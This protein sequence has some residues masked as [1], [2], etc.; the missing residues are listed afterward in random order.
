MRLSDEQYEHIKQTVS[1]TFEEYDIK[2]I[3]INVFEMALKMNL[4]VIP[5]SVL[6]DEKKKAA[7]KISEDGFLLGTSDYEWRIYYND[8]CRSYGRISQTIMHDIGHYALGHSD[9]GEEEEAEAK[10]FA[11]YALAPPPLIHNMS[12]KITIEN[13]QNRFDISHQA[14]TYAYSYYKKWLNHGMKDYT[15]YE[16]KIL[17]LIEDVCDCM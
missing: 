10:F 15:G 16:L 7:L 3:P 11:K 13:L 6:D 4:K 8:V 14:A 5:Y 9:K 2:C 12:E 17:D 1:D